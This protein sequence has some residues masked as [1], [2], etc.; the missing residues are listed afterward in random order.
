MPVAPNLQLKAQITEFTET[1]YWSFDDNSGDM[2]IGSPFRWTVKIEVQPQA[3]SNHTTAEPMFYTGNDVRVGDWFASG[4]G[5]RA[6]SIIS[7]ISQD[8]YTVNCVIEDVERTNLFTDPAQA[9]NG[10][11]DPFSNGVIFR[12][13]ENGLPILG[14]ID[15]LYMPTQSVDDLL[16]RFIARNLM[17]QILVFQELHGMVPGD[18]IYADFEANSGYNKV[19]A[20]NFN[21]AIGIVTGVGVPGLHY[22]TYRPLG[23]L[24]NNVT[25][26]LWGEHGDVFYMDPNEP[27]ALTNIKPPR[28]AVPVYLQL[29]LPTRAI[30][31]ERG[32]D[33]SSNT[34]GAE[35]E[36]NKYDVENVTAGQR[37]FTMP[38]DAKEILYMAING[39]EN[40]NFTF[41]LVSKALVFDPIETGYGVD[42]D[43]EV[44]FIYK[45]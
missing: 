45:T 2:F 34:G 19:T 31:L 4:V 24:I 38:A 3:H 39:I 40:E 7:I 5:G 21:R 1:E 10:L 6:N 14:P 17:D 25:P 32:V 13:A 35:S 36:T 29:D 43:D 22:F 33:N 28:N 27:G 37:T 9:G 18:V 26:P 20:A 8:G 23:R 16:A 42:V 15:E 41:D 44:F 11:C 12:I 30:L